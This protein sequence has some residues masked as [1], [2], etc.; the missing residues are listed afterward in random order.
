[1]IG[2]VVGLLMVGTI[3]IIAFQVVRNV[4]TNI[5]LNTTGWSTTEIS[6]ICEIVGIVMA[7]GVIVL[8]F[9]L[10]AKASKGLT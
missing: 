1:M 5:C 3:G 9:V 2:Q 7:L 10:I 4:A 6:L 8:L